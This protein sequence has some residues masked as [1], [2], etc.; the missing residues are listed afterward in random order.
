MMNLGCHVPRALSPS[1]LT[2]FGLWTTWLLKTVILLGQEF[3]NLSFQLWLFVSP[4]WRDNRA[5][6]A[7][8]IFWRSSLNFTKC[9]ILYSSGLE[10]YI[11]LEISLS[12]PSKQMEWKSDNSSPPTPQTKKLTYS[13]ETIQNTKIGKLQYRFRKCVDCAL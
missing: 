2:F 13:S 6:L 5:M 10:T 8:K 9:P 1:P 4:L 3:T 12:Q 11:H 7:L